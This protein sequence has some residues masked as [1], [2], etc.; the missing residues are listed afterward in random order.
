MKA[1]FFNKPGLENLTFDDYQLTEIKEDEVLV[2]TKC[3]G[4]NPI[5]YYT[6]TGIHGINGPPMK[7]NP[8]PHIAGSEIAGIVIKK[9]S[10][11]KHE[12]RVGDRVIIYNR[13][14]DGTCRYCNNDHEMLCKN[15]G[16]I[17]IITNGGFAEFVK[18]PQQNVLKI[19]DKI[20]WELA[21]SLP[22]SGLA[23]YNAIQESGLKS[24]EYLVIFGGSGNT[25][26][27]SSQI[28]K[29][30]D[31]ITISISNKSWIKEYGVDHVLP[32]NEK[33]REKIFNITNGEMA[34]VVINP[35][36]EKTWK[37]GMDIIGKMGRIVTYG[38]LTGGNLLIDGRLLYNNQ[39][40]IKG[41][42]GGSMKGLLQ[43]VDMAEKQNFK[44]KVWKRFSL[45]DSKKALDMVFSKDKEGRIIIKNY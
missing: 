13:I 19:S 15:G 12:I 2:E 20:N 24:N 5:D 6:I 10:K 32:I 39:I 28:G 41:A 3:I 27:F 17:G 30:I 38:V 18:V 29:I 23:S 7:I 33:L 35:L 16:M 43:L 9:G 42:T 31:A 21:A 11:V 25:G 26:Q 4:V 14:F 34:D 1:L 40:T 36:G 22:I 8:F 44:T 45:E 37:Q